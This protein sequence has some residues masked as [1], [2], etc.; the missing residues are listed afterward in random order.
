M[1][2]VGKII[3]AIFAGVGVLSTIS[4]I[5]YFTNKSKYIVDNDFDCLEPNKPE[6][7][8]N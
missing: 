2:T 3:T 5:L 6:E 8:E 1:K 7:S 4:T